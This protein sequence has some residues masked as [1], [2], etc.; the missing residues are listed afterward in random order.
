[1]RRR[2]YLMRH[3]EVSYFDE[4]GRPLSATRAPLTELGRE[5]AR[6]AGRALRDVRLDRVITSGLPRTLETARLVVAELEAPPT[7]PIE[8]R[9]AGAARRQAQRHRRRPPGGRLPQRVPR[10]RP[11]RRHLPRRR[12]RRLAARPRPARPRAPVRELLGHRAGRPARRRQPRH[13]LLGAGRRTDVLRPSRTVAGVHQHHRR[14]A[15]LGGAGRQRHARGSRP[16]RSPQHKPSSSCSSSTGPTGAPV[17]R[18]ATAAA[19][20]AERSQ[21]RRHASAIPVRRT[22]RRSAP[23][24]TSSRATSFHCRGNR[25]AL[26]APGCSAVADRPGHQRPAPLRAQRGARTRAAAN[27]DAAPYAPSRGSSTTTPASVVQP[28]RVSQRTTTRGLLGEGAYCSCA[29]R[30]GPPTWRPE[31]RVAWETSSAARRQH[32][33]STLRG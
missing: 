21:R 15:R 26:D 4:G 12:E 33:R 2:L 1:M 23:R 20:A 6:A 8:D 7:Q 5:Q 30:S 11:P 25:A 22:R 27:S 16:P 24:Q 14:R 13:P 31:C 29:R 9:P 17:R 32:R 3:A 18:R 28:S 10:R 19:R